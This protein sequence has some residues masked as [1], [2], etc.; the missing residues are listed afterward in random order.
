MPFQ[1]GRVAIYDKS[2]QFAKTRPQPKQSGHLS[3]ELYPK[4]GSPSKYKKSCDQ[5]ESH[6][7]RETA[8]FSP[9]DLDDVM[10]GLLD[11]ITPESFGSRVNGVHQIECL[12]FD[13]H[14]CGFD[15]IEQLRA[16]R[17]LEARACK[18]GNRFNIG[19]VL[20]R[21]SVHFVDFS[22][23][24]FTAQF[25]LDAATAA[26]RGAHAAELRVVRH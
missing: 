17:C 16:A 6:F 1:L 21:N 24:S 15:F 18:S 3:E 5:C 22:A 19:T 4:N 25:T 11:E 2:R 12:P 13:H 7:F 8:P 20:L 26:C 23:K 9:V 10:Q 14:Q